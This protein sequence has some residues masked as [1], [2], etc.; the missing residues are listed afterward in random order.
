M[1]LISSIICVTVCTHMRG[2]A[3]V[4][5]CVCDVN[6]VD[7]TDIMRISPRKGST[8]T[9]SHFVIVLNQNQASFSA[10]GPH[11]MR[12]QRSIAN[13]GCFDG[14]VTCMASSLTRSIKSVRLFFHIGHVFTICSR[15]KNKN[16]RACPL[17]VHMAFHTLQSY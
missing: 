1:Q 17:V 16:Q 14:P 11:E 13:C 10:C 7:G 8:A 12:V 2:S 9:V 6:P 3:K 5:W 15:T 4:V